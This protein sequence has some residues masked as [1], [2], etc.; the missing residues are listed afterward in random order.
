MERLLGPEALDDDLR[1]EATLRPRRMQ[2]YLGQEKVKRNLAVFVQAAK[3]R[4]EPLDHVLLFGPSGLGKTTLAHVI[5]Q[6]MASN[7]K[8]TSGPAIEKAGDLAA[9]LTNLEAEDVL[10]ID[11]IHRLSPAVEE[12]LYP[13]MEDRS[14]DLIIGSGPSARSVRIDIQPFTLVGATTRASLLTAPLRSRFGIIEHLTHY[15]EEELAAIVERSAGVMKIQIQNAGA[16]A[17]ARRARGTPRIANRLLRRVRDFAQLE[18]QQNISE[19]VALSSLDRLEVDS[20]G[21][22]DIDRKILI[23]ILEKFDGGPVGLS[24]LAAALGE[25][26]GAIEEMIEPYLLQ[27]GLIQR[28]PRGRTATRRASEHIGIQPRSP[29]WGLFGNE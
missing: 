5:A 18:E 8:V 14:L 23:L 3:Q 12:I 15:K 24:T 16:V 19:E 22:D 20:L 27:H 4:H 17:I 2:D 13:A 26:R 6:E 11:E 29:Q 1:F 25:D 10:F 7:L 21:L 28:T 9:I